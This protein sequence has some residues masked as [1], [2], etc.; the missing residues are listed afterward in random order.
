M[1]KEFISVIEDNTSILIIQRR[2]VEV[3]YKVLKKIPYIQTCNGLKSW[4]CI[5]L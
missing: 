3:Q 2:T 5:K 1:A 4:I